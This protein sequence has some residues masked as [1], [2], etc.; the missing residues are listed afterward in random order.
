M[1]RRSHGG[2]DP[3]NWGGGKMFEPVVEIL[4]LLLVVAVVAV[5]VIALAVVG[6]FGLL[7][8]RIVRKAYRIV[9]RFRWR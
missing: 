9:G 1:H 6:V 4:A 2:N 8:F 7:A 5:L 3:E